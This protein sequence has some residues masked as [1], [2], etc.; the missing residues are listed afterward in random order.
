MT[1]ELAIHEPQQLEAMRVQ[2][3]F[4]EIVVMAKAVAESGL[5]GIERPSQALALMMIAQ[6]EGRHPALVALE[7]HI[8]KGRPSLKADAMVARFQAAGGRIEYHE[9]SETRCEA[10]FSHPQGG[11]IRLH[12]DLAMARN[13]GLTGDN[14]RKYPRAMMRARVVSEGI[15]TVFPGVAVGIYTPEEVGDFDDPKPKRKRS[16]KQAELIEGVNQAQHSGQGDEPN[17]PIEA[18]VTA[19]VP[20]PDGLSDKLDLGLMTLMLQEVTILKTGKGDPFFTLGLRGAKEYTTINM[21]GGNAGF[22]SIAGAINVQPMSL[23]EHEGVTFPVNKAVILSIIQSSQGD[24][25]NIDKFDFAVDIYTDKP[26]PVEQ[27]KAFAASEPK[28][29]L[30]NECGNDS[31]VEP[32]EGLQPPIDP[33][34]PAP[35]PE[36][37]TDHVFGRMLMEVRRSTGYGSWEKTVEAVTPAMKA[38]LVTEKVASNDIRCVSKAQVTQW[39]AQYAKKPVHAN[40]SEGVPFTLAEA[41]AWIANQDHGK[42]M[43]DSPIPGGN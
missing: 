41:K 40:W 31:P 35:A 30:C 39:T 36:R 5:F 3:S 34:A 23:L 9:Y 28:T 4:D 20:L 21:F 8:I 25:L 15:R 17:V 37:I 2:H 27:A 29:E 6:A 22:G 43:E 11:E 32:D 7:W 26:D 10:S 1:E 12:W 13:A 14:W 18:I 42:P 33:P 16:K 19:V 38:Q 24:Y